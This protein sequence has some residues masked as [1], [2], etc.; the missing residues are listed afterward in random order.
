M[1]WFSRRGMDL[2][3]SET[4]LP[5]VPVVLELNAAVKIGLWLVNLPKHWFKEWYKRATQRKADH[6]T[7]P[8]TT[9]GRSH[10]HSLT[11]FS[12]TVSSYRFIGV[13]N[14]MVMCSKR[15]C[16]KWIKMCSGKCMAKWQIACWSFRNSSWHTFQILRMKMVSV[17]NWSGHNLWLMSLTCLAT[18]TYITT[19]KSTTKLWSKHYSQLD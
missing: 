17:C 8:F 12:N 19:I 18:A 1:S 10:S 11:F 6:S 2:T 13:I 5:W 16:I 9:D 4:W 7:I 14:E 3:Y 15:F